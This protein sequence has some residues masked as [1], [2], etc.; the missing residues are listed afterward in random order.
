ME[1]THVSVMVQQVLSYLPLRPGAVVVDGTLGLAGHSRQF[2]ERIVPGGLLIGIDTDNEMLQ[3]ARKRLEQVESGAT[4]SLHHTDFR[5]LPSIVNQ[6]CL[7]V[8]RPAGANA[9]LLDLGLNNAQIEDPERGITFKQDGPLDM[10]LDRSSGEP[11]SAILN[12][13]SAPQIE[14]ILWDYADERWAKKISQVIVE[15]RKTTPLKTTADLVD[16]VLAAIPGALR[17]KRIHPATRT[18]QAVRIYVNQELAGLE[19]ALMGAA[20]SLAE[21]GV[22]VIL[23]YHSGED[24][25]AKHAIR[26]LAQT[27]DFEDLARKPILPTEEEIRIN[28]KARSAKLRAVRR[29]SA[30]EIHLH[31]RRTFHHHASTASVQ[32]SHDCANRSVDQAEEGR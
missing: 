8:G 9:I 25:A 22:L 16:C 3:E 31:G 12:R 18:F 21:H 2:L 1:A 24:R 13:L 32:K 27:G 10:R 6:V 26:L 15:R 11:A 4:I 23:S 14:Q 7:G 29:R 30:E 20:K 28:P 19:D 5:E 17:D